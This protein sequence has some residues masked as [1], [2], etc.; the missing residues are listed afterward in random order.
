ML[1]GADGARSMALI[2]AINPSLSPATT[3]VIVLLV[4]AM[5]HANPLISTISTACSRFPSAC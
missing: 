5:N 4:P 2:G 3:A 1:V